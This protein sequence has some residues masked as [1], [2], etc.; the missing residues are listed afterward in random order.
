MGTLGAQAQA[1]EPVTRGRLLLV[2]DE[3]NIL[4][5]IRRVLR[6][7]EWEIETATDAEAGLRT[8]ERF[9]P[10]VVIS[11]FRM[12][13]MNGVEFLNQVKL[14]APR[15]QRIML[16]GQADQQ[17]IE[18]AINRSE[19][20]RFISKPWNDSHLVLTVK[21]AFEQYALHAEND[22]LYRVTQEQNAE[23][24]HLNADLEERVALRTRLLST[25]K[26]EWEL[27][28]DCMET[29]LAVVR[30]RD[31]A[32]RRANVAYA[33]VA[34]RSIEEVP[35]DVP[36]H[37]YL[38]GRDTPCA[39][40]PLPSAMETG[41]GARGEVQQGGRS[42]VV[43][44]YPFAGDDRAVC[45]YRDVTEEQAMTRRLIETEKMAAVG[46]LAGGVAHEINNPL[47]GILA[48]A[49]LM[50][51]DAGRSESDLESLKLIEE[52]ALRCKR[53]VESLLKFSRH[54]R[55]EDRRLFD[56]SKC[57]EDAAV[58]FRAQLKSMPKVELKLG[59]KDGLPKVYGDPG[60]LA[61]VVLNL[62]Q[63][64]LQSLPKA[65]GRLTL[66]T[67]R[68]GDRTFFAV[69]DTGTGIEEKHLPRIF[70]PSFTTKPPGEGTGLGLSI[71]YRIV[72][73]HGG[74]FQVDT[75]VG[76]GS[77]FTVFLPIPLQLERLP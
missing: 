63:N 74:T 54:S 19:I 21:S 34:R 20:F 23:L 70:E 25:A 60:T 8:L 33:Q 22:R 39:G 18:E 68:E 45:T 24:K 72:Q 17:A 6:R 73:D 41:K 5:S 3:E 11:D 4:K 49:Q 40:C 58:L 51:R 48:F 55:V 59:L 46:Q 15:A 27:S 14:Q 52:S 69:T 10:E 37:Q 71:A 62:L 13:G 7:G 47:G 77:R 36:C 64:G 76:Q 61:Q 26:R 12:P 38:F 32:V 35:S 9:Q 28:F 29:P 50:S 31:F 56:L 75:H 16:T 42:Y 65:E 44:A 67:G 53:I 57:V 2:D 30:A 66:E 43:A 1:Q